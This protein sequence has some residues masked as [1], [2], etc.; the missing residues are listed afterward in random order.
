MGKTAIS[1]G[2]NVDFELIV[3]FLKPVESQA[4]ISCILMQEDDG[5]PLVDV[6]GLEH[7]PALDFKAVLRLEPD[8]LVLDSANGR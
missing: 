6:S 7:E 2:H 8:F 3:H 1:E 4:E 5:L